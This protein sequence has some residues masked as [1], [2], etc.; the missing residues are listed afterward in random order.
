M[1]AGPDLVSLVYRADWTQLTLSAVANDGTEVLLAPGRRYRVTAGGHLTGCTG[2]RP[3]RLGAR[4][5]QDGEGAGH[6]VSG[7]EPPL[8]D[9]L[10]PAWLLISSQLELRGAARACGRDAFR[11]GVTR[12]VGRATSGVPAQFRAGRADVLVD[13]DLGIL[14]RV[15]WLA[16]GADPSDTEVTELVSLDLDPVL[17]PALFAPP[18]GSLIAESMGDAL[19]AGGPSWTL[20]KTVGG[21]AAGGLGAWTRYAPAA[22]PPAAD[23]AAEQAAEHA[24][25]QA[26]GPADGLADGLA[27]GP[28]DDAATILPDGPAPNRSADGRPAGPPVSAEV[29]GLL[30]DRT[31]DGFT[32]T[33]HDWTDLP[34]MLSQVP[35]GA[36]RAGF[37]GLGLLIDAIS[38]RPATAHASFALR[39]DGGGRYRIDYPGQEGRLPVMV[40]CDGERCWQVYQDRVTTGPAEPPPTGV[41][42]MLDPSWLL[43]C[44]LSGGTPVLVGE[45]RAYRINVARGAANTSWSLPSLFP[46]AV[47]VMDAELGLV[48]RLT[49]Y[50]GDR[51]VRRAELRDITPLAGDLAIDIPPDLPVT[52]DPGPGGD[53]GPAGDGPS[54]GDGPTPGGP[55]RVAF[56]WKAAGAAAG[57]AATDVAKGVAKEAAK[58]AGDLLRRLSDR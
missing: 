27:D 58:A 40:A 1:S 51:P 35:A 8:P 54:A 20:L 33:V 30:H 24:A 2:D 38:E 12:R 9:L 39:V 57:Q 14:L 53:R 31:P 56:P 45:R 42:E 23:Q 18:P 21:L 49:S 44:R 47:A 48:L 28:A 50:I 4:A 41:A 52:E 43:G 3:W 13:A 17:D 16:D 34:A 6:W 36:R 11:V 46:S 55:Y 7:P 29:L 26:G 15:A 25:E 5:V 10:C 19:R 32:A 37:G 22:R